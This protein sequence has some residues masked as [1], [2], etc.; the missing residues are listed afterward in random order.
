MEKTGEE[1]QKDLHV[2][3]SFFN[4]QL[5]FVFNVFIH[6]SSGALARAH[7]EDNGGCAGDGIAASKNSVLGGD[8][9]FLIRYD[10]TLAVWR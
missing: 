10:A 9:V 7:S 8:A 3:R 2:C 5:F 1:K 6:R 4:R